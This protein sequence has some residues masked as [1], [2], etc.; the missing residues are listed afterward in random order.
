ML[1]RDNQQKAAVD[2]ART[3]G[4]ILA[5]VLALRRAVYIGVYAA[6]NLA[7]LPYLL[8]GLTWAQI[9]V[10]TAVNWTIA[11]LGI[12]RSF[13]R[14]IRQRKRSSYPAVAMLRVADAATVSDAAAAALEI[15]EQLLC[16]QAAFVT[17]LSPGGRHAV[18]A[19]KGVTPDAAADRL[20]L[21]R[22]V[23]DTALSV[24]YPMEVPSR[25]GDIHVMLVPI[26]A[27]KRAIGV[28]Y[29]AGER[30]SDLGDRTL[31][32]EVGSAIGMSLENLR[33]KELL[34]QKESR[35]RNVITGAP[36]VL[37]SIDTRGVCN[38]ME[39]KGL[40]GFGIS[41][42]LVIGREAEDV[43]RAYPQVL[44]SL[45]R[46][47]A[48]EHV[49]GTVAMTVR[50]VRSVFEYRLL[51]ELDEKGR[52]TG[53][54]GVAHDITERR[55]AE[56]ALLESQRALETLVS[57][58]P[59]FAYR[60]HNDRD[61][62]MEYISAGVEEIT[63]YSPA[64][65]T[66]GA[67]GFN[68]V[69][70]YD[71]RERVWEAVQSA[72]EQQENYRLEY[73]VVARD[74]TEKW[75]WEQGQAILD[76][77]G[78]VVALEGFISEITERKRAE[79][80]LAESEERF[81][82]LFD[83]ARDGIFTFDFNGALVAAN[84]R[85]VELSGYTRDEVFAAGAAQL[86][87]PEEHAAAAHGVSRVYRGEAGSFEVNIR[88]K[89]GSLRPVDVAAR[90]V[91]DK[92]GAPVLIQGIARDI[93]ERKQAEETIRRLAY[94]DA[95]TGLPN[96]AL[97]E[98]RLGV[99]L[100]QARREG[101]ALALMF[102]D[103][104][105]FKVVNDTLGHSAGDRLLEAVAADLCTIVRDGDTIA[106]IGGDEF[107]VI[108][109]AVDGLE[110]ATEVA[111]RILECLRRARM[112]DG[113]EFRTTASIG[114]T[115]YPDDGGDAATLLRNADTA[116]YRAKDKGRD[117]F[118]LYTSSMNE[119]V[120]ERLS[121][122]NDLRHALEREQLRVF[123][124]PILDADTGTLTGA[125]ALLRWRHPVRGMVPPDSF[126]PF[127][128]ESGLIVEIGL[129]VLRE[130]CEQT[131]RWRQSG[132]HLL[133][134]A[135]NLSARQLQQEDLVERVTEIIAE[136]GVS[137]RQVQLEITEGA[138]LRD[139]DRIIVTLHALR[140]MG[141]EIA[142][143][144]FGT[145]YSSLTYLKRFPINAVKV[146]RSF[147]RDLERD[148]SDAAIVSTVVAMAENLRLKVI[149]EGVESEG[150][151]NFLRERGCDE[152]QGYLV[153][154]AVPPEE[155]EPFFN[156]GPP[157]LRATVPRHLRAT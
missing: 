56:E 83:N 4:E 153:S 75:V 68:D 129:W 71:D 121:F 150:Q 135:V 80:S 12:H 73:R 55:R 27:F 28:I 145:G 15:I 109:P 104:D 63:G 120:L 54:I 143:D 51:P 113:Q 114:L 89:D 42:D 67:R 152:F 133:R 64:E 142:L 21:H 52:A 131:R 151:L 46:A 154:P 2:T 107:T 147:V 3:P 5:D 128:E 66:S 110:D 132:R 57:N 79:Q 106:R 82:D 112:I 93:T 95:L 60:C 23:L 33:Q 58:L 72:V 103:L 69:I 1:S 6:I 47:F 148:P 13:S 8:I 76:D 61:W 138:V 94:H 123:Y 84:Q 115:M 70:H 48:G 122:E 85:F 157:A 39:G 141:I 96:R 26:V 62:M 11:G 125:E 7:L 91:T 31:L 38:F 45:R 9:G 29:L 50:E 44:Q 111:D 43:F 97:M 92:S 146:D 53:V 19:V 32:S 100:A 59:G 35:L 149:A 18:M 17:L 24:R 22:R 14:I 20:D 37:F 134:V 99:A 10:I 40:D 36:I 136:T 108:L 81:R 34:L 124:Q 49:T 144:D 74:G 98:D 41:P 16:P 126:I 78:D 118:Q 130:A 102:L 77:A 88:C 119:W 30:G 65:F 155:F 116:M 86:I 25:V 137:P 156:G 127:A 105:R 139:E 90:V 101:K 87:P 117:N 140:D